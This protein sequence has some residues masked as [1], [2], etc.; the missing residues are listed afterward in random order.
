MK[1]WK[2]FL[3]ILVRIFCRKHETDCVICN[4]IQIYNTIYYIQIKFTNILK[5]R[6]L[7]GYMHAYVKMLNTILGRKYVMEAFNL[8]EEFGHGFLPGPL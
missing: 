8:P 5:L 2:L 4:A 3:F 7:V 6:T 1:K